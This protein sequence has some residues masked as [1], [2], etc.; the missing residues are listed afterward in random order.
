MPVSVKFATP[1]LY[2]RDWPLTFP[3][4][5]HCFS[6][7]MLDCSASCQALAVA[8]NANPSYWM[9]TERLQQYLPTA[10]QPGW[11]WPGALSGV[12]TRSSNSTSGTTQRRQTCSSERATPSAGTANQ[13]AMLPAHGPSS[14][15]SAKANE[16]MPLGLQDVCLARIQ[17]EIGKA[18]RR[19]R[20][21]R[22]VL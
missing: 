17:L 9:I 15:S 11:R 13:S 1:P 21:Q 16:S 6:S 2:R 18:A 5:G 3:P 20:T 8:A 22:R 4:P 14:A 10:P 12:P 7:S 19:R